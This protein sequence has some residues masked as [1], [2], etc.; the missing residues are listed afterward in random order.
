[1]QLSLHA[2]YALRVLVYVGTHRDRLVR[3]EA[4][5]KI[6]ACQL[7]ITWEEGDRALFERARAAGPRPRVD[8]GTAGI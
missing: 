6:A 5:W 4:G 8:V 7:V 1:M 3:T 2:D